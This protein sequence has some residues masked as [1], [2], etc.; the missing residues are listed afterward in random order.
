MYE[1]RKTGINNLVAVYGVDK[2]N[3]GNLCSGS[4]T[5]KVVTERIP[6]RLSEMQL[7][8]AEGIYVLR[9]CLDGF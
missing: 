7:T 1:Y 3:S 2:V 8:L 5:Y 9:E 4:A 6:K